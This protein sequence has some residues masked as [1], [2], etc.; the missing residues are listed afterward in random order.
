MGKKVD[1]EEKADRED[2]DLRLR[3]LSSTVSMLIH[4]LEARGEFSDV[5][6]AFIDEMRA[7]ERRLRVRVDAATD[8]HGLWALVSTEIARD[9]QGAA[10]ALA[11]CIE[12]INAQ[13]FRD[14]RR[15]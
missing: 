7:R 10:D 3:T 4:D 6:Q 11:L 12:R 1:R 13:A 14:V 5:H 8:A 9:L 2:L 15:G